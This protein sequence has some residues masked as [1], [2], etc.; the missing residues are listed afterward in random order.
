[1]VGH[2]QVGIARQLELADV[3]VAFLEHVELGDQHLGIDDHT[4]ADDRSDVG[5]QDP[6]RHQ[7]QLE[8]VA[9]DDDRVS[10]VVARLVT[11]DERALLGE[12]I[13]KAAL[14][15]VTPVGTDDHR[16]R[17]WPVSRNATPITLTAG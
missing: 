15:L 5:V 6:A 11:H 8:H 9:V 16:A 14:A 3:D 4:V 12:I 2:D 10:G 7:L 17:H 1:M 13:G